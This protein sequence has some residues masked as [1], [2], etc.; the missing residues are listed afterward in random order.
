LAANLW[1]SAGYNYFGFYDKD[2]SGQDY[3]NPGYFMRMRFKFDEH[4]L[5]GFSNKTLNDG[6]Q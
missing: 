4:L 5:D 1:L 3:T 2:L 6:P